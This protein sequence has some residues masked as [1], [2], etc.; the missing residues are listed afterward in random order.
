MAL[1]LVF[2][3]AFLGSLSFLRP[4]TCDNPRMRVIATPIACCIALSQ[5]P[6]RGRSKYGKSTGHAGSPWSQ[7]PARGGSIMRQICWKPLPCRKFQ[8]WKVNNMATLWETLAPVAKSSDGKVQTID[9][10]YKLQG[11]MLQMACPAC[12]MV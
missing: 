7:N 9:D 4:H 3:W 10:D 12:C 1:Y 2:H 11:C 8:L 5:N 6:A